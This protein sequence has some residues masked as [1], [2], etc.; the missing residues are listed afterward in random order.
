MPTVP[1][2]DAAPSI[3]GRLREIQERIAAAAVRAGRDAASVQ[4]VAVSKTHPEDDVRQAIGCGQM[5]FG[6]NRVQ[7]AAGKFASLR[8][9]YPS[10]RLHLI[11][12]LQTNKA[13]DAV[14][15]ADVIETLDRP[16]LL[17]ALTLAFEREGRTPDVL[18]QVNVG[19]EPQK[20]G[21]SRADADAFME[22]CRAR[23]GKAV[24]GVMCIPPAGEDPSGHFSWLTAFA[25]RHGLGVISM[26]MSA[27][28]EIAV[29]HGA[30]HVRVGSA[31]FGSRP[32]P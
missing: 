32:A 21:V 27:D 29:A 2:H 22:R 8:P 14:A 9:H 30:T 3:S 15:A 26:G 10:L 6:E 28:F 17:D 4:L 31:L 18:I 13:R 25:G 16:K 1:P 19:D 7:E 12:P 5:V 24:K 23:L 20:A 11:G